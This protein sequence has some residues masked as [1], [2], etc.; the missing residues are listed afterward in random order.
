MAVR[1]V[2][3]RVNNRAQEFVCDVL[4]ATIIRSSE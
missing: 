1:K 3:I 4:A 2:V